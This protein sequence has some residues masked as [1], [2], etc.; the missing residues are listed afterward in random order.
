MD[1]QLYGKDDDDDRDELHAA[2]HG[3]D[4]AD[5]IHDPRSMRLRQAEYLH[6]QGTIQTNTSRRGA[7]HKSRRR[8]QQDSPIIALHALEGYQGGN[9]KAPG[10]KPGARGLA[11]PTG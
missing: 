11:K 8:E 10:Q 3:G 4:E 6:V 1:K 5:L 2:H 9:T 7:N